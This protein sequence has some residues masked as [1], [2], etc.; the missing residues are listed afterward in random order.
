MLVG[1]FG[2]M[3]FGLLLCWVVV[4]GFGCGLVGVI[5]SSDLC[6]SIIISSML[7]RMLIVVYV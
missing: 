1:L 6:I 2:V 4:C 5:G 3:V 7:I